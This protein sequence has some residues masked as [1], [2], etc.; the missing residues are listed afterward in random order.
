MWGGRISRSLAMSETELRLRRC[1]RRCIRRSWATRYSTSPASQPPIPAEQHSGRQAVL[2]V[3]PLV[4]WH[5][6]LAPVHHPA[7]GYAHYHHIGPEKKFSGPY[8]YHISTSSW[9]LIQDDTFLGA[10]LGGQDPGS[11]RGPA[12]KLYYHTTLNTSW[13]L[14]VLMIQWICAGSKGYVSTFTRS[15]RWD[16]ILFIFRSLVPGFLFLEVYFFEPLYLNALIFYPNAKNVWKSD[17]SWEPEKIWKFEKIWKKL[18]KLK[19][20]WKMIKF[21]KLKKN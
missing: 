21:E 9:R 10:S 13:G 7:A 20:I 1:C 3:V 15:M 19:K 6:Q 18:K 12:R 14:E 4:L 8:V 16:K 11:S 2:L 5:Q 17:K